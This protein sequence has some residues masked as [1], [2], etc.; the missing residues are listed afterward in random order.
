MIATIDPIPMFAEVD[1]PAAFQAADRGSIRA[2]RNFHWASRLDLLLILLGA[3]STSWAIEANQGRTILAITG[4]LSLG[5][6]LLIGLYI[7]I[8]DAEKTW[9]S[10]RAVAESIKTMTWRYVTKTVPYG[11]TLSAK[12][13]DAVYTEQLG[14]ILRMPRNQH[15]T[16]AGE[17]SSKAQITERMRQI[18]DFSTL[19]RKNLYVRDRLKDEQD[20]YSTKAKEN[21]KNGSLLLTIIILCQ[22]IAMGSAILL[23]RWPDFNFNFAS[24]FSAAAAAAI[25]WQELKGNQELAYAYGQ[26]SHELGLIIAREM[27]VTSD[28]ELSLFVSDAEKSISREHTMWIARRDIV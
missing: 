11:Q 2:K 6:G 26:A 10:Y 5:L 24:V 7:K 8:S 19:L 16:L 14:Q 28:E 27:H 12:E 20:W 21:S 25:A 18:R 22:G 17:A 4:A 9:F 13:V 23:V 3:I 15:A 1:F